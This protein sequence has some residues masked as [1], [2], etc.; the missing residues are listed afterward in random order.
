MATR[1]FIQ[2][3]AVAAMAA[4]ASPVWAQQA[5]PR[6]SPRDQLKITVLNTQ[7]SRE[8]PVSADGNIDF[9]ELGPVKVAGLTATEVEAELSKRLKTGEIHLSPQITVEINQSLNKRVNVLGLVRVIGPI[10][11]AGDMTL[12]DA[13]VRAGGRQPES[14]DEVL[15]VRQ[16]K[17]GSDGSQQIRINIAA[18]EKGDMSRN[19][20]LED[21][22]QVIVQKAQP[23]FVSGEVKA[24]GPYNVESGTTVLQLIAM[25]GGV[26]ERGNPNRVQIKRIVDGKETTIKDIKPS[27]VVK[28]G[29]TVIVGRRLM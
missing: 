26:T 13:I 15:V 16:P 5:N 12:L 19:I 27:D 18:I 1:H 28:P 29:D 17:S 7:W 21:G 9:P 10:A 24:Q 8:Y 14:S 22:D 23:V 20:A 2:M 3:V 25:A 4:V 6:V 11:F